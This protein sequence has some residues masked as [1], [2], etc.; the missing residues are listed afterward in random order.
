MTKKLSDNI[1]HLE[2]DF[3]YVQ[4]IIILP[5][6]LEYF[7]LMNDYYEPYKEQLMKNQFLT[8]TNIVDRDIV[9]HVIINNHNLNKMSKSLVTYCLSIL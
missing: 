1:T 5:R 2:F 7:I 4:P 3:K 8:Y 9:K 6:Y